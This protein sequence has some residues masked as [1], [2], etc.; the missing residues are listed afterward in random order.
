MGMRLIF[1]AACLY[2]TLT[3]MAGHFTPALL[4]KS[5][6]TLTPAINPSVEISA[7]LITGTEADQT[8]ITLTVTSD[9]PVSGDQNVSLDVTGFDVFATDYNLSSINVVILDGETT[10]S[11]TF[12]VSDDAVYEGN[13]TATIT[14]VNPSPGIML[15]TTI[16]V[17]ITLVDDEFCPVFATEPDNVT[18]INSSCNMSCTA[19][20]G[21]II[22]P[23]G[24]PCPAGSTIQYFDGSTWSYTIPTYNQSGPVQ[25]LSTRCV[26]DDD[27]TYISSESTPIA[28]APASCVTLTCYL[29]QDGDGYGN[30]ASSQSFCTSC[31]SGFVANGLDCNDYDN[32]VNTQTISMPPQSSVFSANVRGYTFTCPSAIRITSLRVPT[33]ASTGPQSIAV[34]KFNSP[35]PTYSTTTNDFTVLYLTQNNP[36]S[37]DILVDIDIN[38]NDIIGILGQRST[39]NSYGNGTNSFNINGINVP[40][41]RLGMQFPLTTTAPQ[42]LWVE[43]SSSNISRVFFTYC[44]NEKVKNITTNVIYGT[45]QDAIT[46]ATD[47]D[48]IMLLDDVSE[49]PLNIVHSVCIDANGFDLHVP[50]TLNIPNN[51]E[52]CWPTGTLTIDPSG[53]I[54]NMGTL[55]NNGTI[56]YQG[57]SG[58]YAN[59]GNM[60]GTGT[61][62]G[63]V[64]N[65]GNIN[66]GN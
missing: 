32:M 19:S 29:D 53:S 54:V 33:D 47:G 6:T 49:S 56:E 50:G 35:V 20:G 14:L 66:P 5:L 40:F 52:L 55:K 25:N 24:T 12:T 60:I 27:N 10:G 48:E 28:T 57:G 30:A 45:L 17:N 21:Q 16:S 7:S 51:K 22:A 38:A 44:P 43:P 13:E 2:L 46:A 59:Q 36:A 26:C 64:I 39:W 61:F 34:L 23:S 62:T 31:G 65:L 41:T 3:A 1:T 4:N 63:T 11:V 37:G 9:L 18:I 15:G 8:V 42:D 58:F